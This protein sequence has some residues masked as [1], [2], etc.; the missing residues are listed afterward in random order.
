[1]GITT[2][3]Q[4]QHVLYTENLKKDERSKLS[5]RNHAP[6]PLCYSFVR[7][8]NSLTNLVF[9]TNMLKNLLFR[10]RL[11]RKVLIRTKE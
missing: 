4:F 1:M 2:R 5:E 8:Y 10:T 7:I 6:L 9:E 3:E 11:V